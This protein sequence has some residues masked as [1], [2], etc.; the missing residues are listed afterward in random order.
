MDELMVSKK[1]SYYQSRYRARLREKGYVKREIWIPPDYTKSLK[2]C[3][4]ALRIGVIPIIPKTVTEK[5]MSEDANWTTET[6]YEALAQSAPAGEGA[7]EVELVEGADPGILITMTEFGDLP[8]LMSVSG[9]QIL[10]DTLLWP[11]EEVDNAAAFN[12]MILKTH[13]LLPLSTFG[14]RPGPDGR[15]YYEMFGSLSAGSILESVLF[16]IETLAD[17]A[18]Q[19]AAAYQSDLKGVA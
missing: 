5:K 2:D 3:E 11:V 12:E 8:L 6:L 4:T 19:A 15:D 10:V 18:M 17:N 13:K 9:S 1:S 7:I 14:I 16:E